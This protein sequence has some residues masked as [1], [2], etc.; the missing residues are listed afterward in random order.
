MQNFT[1][2]KRR[3]HSLLATRKRA[4]INTVTIQQKPVTT[5]VTNAR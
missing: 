1:A 4:Q 5:T 2:V 3:S